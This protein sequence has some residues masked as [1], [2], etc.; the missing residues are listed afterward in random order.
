MVITKDFMACDLLE[1][2]NLWWDQVTVIPEDNKIAVFN[3]GISNGLKGKI[4][5][6][7]HNIPI[8]IDGDKLL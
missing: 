1:F 2:I 5:L 6:G 4:P 3:K 7:G 8:S